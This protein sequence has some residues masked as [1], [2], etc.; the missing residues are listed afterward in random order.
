[1]GTRVLGDHNHHPSIWKDMVRQEP[2][3]FGYLSGGLNAH[4]VAEAAHFAPTIITE[5]D[6]FQSVWANSKS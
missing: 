1:M 4:S 2:D 6:N 5:Q 3:L